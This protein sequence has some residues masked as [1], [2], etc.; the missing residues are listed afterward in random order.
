MGV[1]WQKHHSESVA[2]ESQ[3]VLSG[4]QNSDGCELCYRFEFGLKKFWFFR[5]V[6]QSHEAYCRWRYNKMRPRVNELCWGSKRIQGQTLLSSTEYHE[7]VISTHFSLPE[8]GGSTRWWLRKFFRTTS[9]IR[10]I[11]RSREVL[12]PFLIDYR[13]FFFSKH[14]HNDIN[15][16]PT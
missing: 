9:S 3:R 11:H 7:K 8:I 12:I 15:E 4:S 14:F 13:W 10:R 2:V 5:Q 6:L 16:L 1:I